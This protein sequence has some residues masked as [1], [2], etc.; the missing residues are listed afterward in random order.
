MKKIQRLICSVLLLACAWNVCHAANSTTTVEQVSSAVTV[1][2]DV[3][4]VIT[5]TTPFATA[6]SV[7]ITNTDHAVVIIKSVK[8]SVVIKS[9]LQYVYINGAQAVSGTNC[10]V[11]L[12][13]MGTIILP[14]ASDIAPLTC[15]TGQNFTGTACSDYTEGHSGGYMKTLTTLMLNNQI[16]SFKLKRGYMV[17]FAV[18]TGGWGYSR[19]FIADKADLEVSELPTIL[20]QRI[21]SYR[22]FPWY[23]FGKKGL[24][25]NTGATIVDALNV[26]GCYSFG[27]G[28][29]R[30]PDAECVAHHIYE[31]W[32]SSS[33]CGSVT[34]STHMKTN[35]EPRNTSDDR[36]QDLATILNNWQ[37]LMRT[38]M[39]LCSPSSW[40]GSDYWNGT[41][42]VKTFLDSIDARGWRCDIVD[43]HCYWYPTGSFNNLANYWYPNMKR[44]I[45]I[46]EWVWGASWNSNG[47]FSGSATESDNASAVKTICNILNSTGCIERYFYWNSESDPSRIYKNN[48]L[49]A[50]G[51]YYASMD[52]GIGYNSSYEFIPKET[53]LEP[54]TNFSFSF[55]ATRKVASLNWTDPNGDL[56]SAITVQRKTPDSEDWEDV[57]SITPRDKNSSSGITYAIN[58]TLTTLLPGIYKYRVQTQEYNGT[59][60]YSSEGTFSISD[61]DTGIQFGNLELIDADATVTGAFSTAFSTR[62]ALFTGLMTLNNSN[63][64]TAPHFS[65]SAITASGFDYQCDPWVYQSNNATNFSKSE[66]QPF[67]ALLEGNYTYGAMDIEVGSLLLRDTTDVTFSTPF[68]E[69]VTPVVIATINRATIANQ[70]VMHKIW[71]VT[72]TGF[73]ACVYYE[74]GLGSKPVTNQRLS[75]LAATPGHECIDATNGIW[76][77]A[78]IGETPVYGT[79]QRQETFTVSHTDADD[80]VVTD[81]ILSESP[82]IFAESQTANTP[83]PS[84]L[85]KGTE[86]TKTYTDE[87]G[88][89]YTYT[90]AMRVRRFVDTSVT[91][92]GTNLKANADTI[93]WL[94]IH[95]TLSY[96]PN[97]TTSIL[98]PSMTA[99][100]T[101]LH[102]HVA[103]RI[104]KVDGIDSFELYTLSGTHVVSTAVQEPGVYVVRAADKT[105]K[106]VVK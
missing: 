42:F 83:V 103:N 47:A 48:A 37:N 90:Y 78:G 106:V 93:G 41:G 1:S 29:S 16:R 31:D 64:T 33:S 88:S 59:V 73:K 75:Y 25:N 54:P 45:W 9:W 15:Y 99:G 92:T 77:A 67:M 85:R 50:A 66:E 76:L 82:Y 23:N 58:D 43:A 24:A 65:S 62:P 97:G 101:P 61:G 26:T 34:Y 27:N 38:G 8:P 95:R 36:P 63:I 84:S 91:A 56:S 94:L 11:K 79:T 86:L 96:N 22:I 5:S 30:L 46:S 19:C 35:N 74:Q 89:Q 80:N 7:N 51:E 102:V 6:G 2:Q 18:G 57:K 32:P 21:S 4:Y 55:N 10:Q 81:T 100:D 20:D 49:T 3:D 98:T 39:R 44:P 12:Y 40:D 72:N 28:E 17:T 13:D 70:P 53:R 52:A 71:D 68:P 14:Y 69:G 104:I 60:Y 87:E 105:A